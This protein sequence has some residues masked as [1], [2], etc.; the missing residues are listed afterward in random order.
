MDILSQLPKEQPKPKTSLKS[1]VL[2]FVE[3]LLVFAA[4]VMVIYFFIAQPH[5]VSGSSMFP[6]FKG[7]DYIITSKISYRLGT[8]QRGQ[9]IVFKNPKDESQDFIKRIIGLPGESVKVEN[10]RV[11]VNDQLLSEPYVDSQVLTGPGAFMHEGEEVEVPADHFVVMGDNRI[12]SSDSREWGFI[13]KDE[14]IGLAFFRYWPQNEIGLIP[15]AH[16]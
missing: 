12:A 11:Y 15:Q 8:A 4:I 14:I 10:G 5:K 7:G 3:T 13:H 2:E 6:N 16:Y 9:I 1:H